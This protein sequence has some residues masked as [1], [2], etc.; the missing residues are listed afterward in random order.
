MGKRR[1][2]SFAG[3]QTSQYVAN[4]PGFIN[5]KAR[6]RVSLSSFNLFGPLFHHFE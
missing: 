6:A 4:F 2:C 3:H 5:N 1:L